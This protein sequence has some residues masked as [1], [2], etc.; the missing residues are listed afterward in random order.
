M[1]DTNNTADF[2]TSL[3]ALENIVQQ[4]ETGKLSLADSL[5][6]FEQGVA[7]SRNCQTLLENAEL[8]IQQLTDA[9]G[10]PELSSL[11][12]EPEPPTA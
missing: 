5:A 4:L 2:E 3:A 8:R 11:E 10:K 9:N 1:S 12:D 6:A 7:L